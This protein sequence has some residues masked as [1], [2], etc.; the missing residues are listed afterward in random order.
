VPE[1]LGLH[2]RDTNSPLVG[3]RFLCFVS[4]S[5]CN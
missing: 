5:L 1:T 3:K 4:L 2:S